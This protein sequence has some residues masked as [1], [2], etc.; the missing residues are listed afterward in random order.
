MTHFLSLTDALSAITRVLSSSSRSVSPTIVRVSQALLFECLK[1]RATRA[2]A[3]G[4]RMLPFLG[5]S[6]PIVLTPA[7][8][9]LRQCHV[10]GSYISVQDYRAQ[11][12]SEVPLVKH[13]STLDF[14]GI[15]IL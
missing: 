3:G 4:A 13:I 6:R 9:S 7:P 8:M 2:D 5:D 1:R 10:C 12:V 15:P 11:R 14:N